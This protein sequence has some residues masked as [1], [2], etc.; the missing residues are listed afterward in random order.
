MVSIVD[1]R[2]AGPGREPSGEATSATGV[3]AGWDAAATGPA[4]EV[5]QVA[6]TRAISEVIAILNKTPIS[7][8]GPTPWGTPRIG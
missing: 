7:H 2:A 5:T 4:A 6:L 3:V 8:P 1:A